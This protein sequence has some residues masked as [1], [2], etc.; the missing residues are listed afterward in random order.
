MGEKRV[1]MP[2]HTTIPYRSLVP[3]LPVFYHLD[4]L[5]LCLFLLEQTIDL[6]TPKRN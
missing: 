1:I 2:K 4:L 3:K 6:Q 5:I